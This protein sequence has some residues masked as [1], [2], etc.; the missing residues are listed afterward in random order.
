MTTPIAAPHDPRV[1]RYCEPRVG[2][3]FDGV[4]APTDRVYVCA[5]GV[6]LPSD[7]VSSYGPWE[8]AYLLPHP[9]RLLDAYARPNVK[10]KPYAD[11]GS[12]VA[13]PLLVWVDRGGVVTAYY[14]P[15]D[16]CGVP[17]RAAARAYREAERTVV[18]SV[19]TGGPAYRRKD[20]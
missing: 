9:Q 4:A 20:S 14:A 17:S 11:C 2:T 10:Q 8:L 3:H 5:A 19:D 13:D 7:G 12:G 18:A 15:F 16:G 6:H 1:L